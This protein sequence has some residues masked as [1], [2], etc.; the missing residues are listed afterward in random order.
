MP[1]ERTRFQRRTELSRLRRPL[2]PLLLLLAAGCGDSTGP[3]PATRYVLQSIFGQLPYLVGG[4]R[5]GSTEITTGHILQ[6]DDGT[7]TISQTLRTTDFGIVLS[8]ET[9]SVTCTW[10]D[11]GSDL[12][13][14]LPEGVVGN[15]S[16][17]GHTLT[18]D[19]I[20]PP[21]SPFDGF[22]YLPSIYVRL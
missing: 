8:I 18:I 20:I 6:N 9:A 4:M 15:G 13:F 16:L 17:V 3:D 14:T 5:S 21:T 19:Y 7:C 12:T 2:F 22:L 11:D 1:C 10:T